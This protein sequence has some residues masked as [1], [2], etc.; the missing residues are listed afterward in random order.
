MSAMENRKLG[1]FYY[2]RAPECPKNGYATREEA[3]RYV[4][5]MRSWSWFA[6]AVEYRGRWYAMY[7]Y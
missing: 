1:K 4:K 6:R 2:W 5:K 3:E 7:R